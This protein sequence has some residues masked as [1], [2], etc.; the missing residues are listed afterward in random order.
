MSKKSIVLWSFIL[1][2][3]IIQYF[4]IHPVYDLQR[5]E[6][7]HLDLGK[8]LAWGYTS[9][10]PLTSWTSWLM[11]SSGHTLFWLKFFPALYGALT[12]WV[13]WKIIEELKGNWF[14]LILGAIATTFSILFRI[15]SLYQPNSLDYLCWTLLY[16]TLIKYTNTQHRNWLFAAAVAFAIGFLN[17]YNILFLVFGLFPALLL[18]EQRKWFLKKDFYL[19]LALALLLISPNL[20]WQFQHHLPVIKHMAELRATQLVN[21]NRMDLFKD[22]L[23]FFAG[24]DFVMIAGLIALIIYPPFRPH[25]FVLFSYIFTLLIFS[26]FQ[27][28]SYYA[29]GLI[30]VL[31]GFGTV[32]LEQLCS[33]GWT[34]RLR[35]VAI[36]LP[37][38]V[39]P[40][41]AKRTL[42]L[43]SPEEIIKKQATDKK[44]GVSRWEDGKDHPLPQDYAD[45]LGW[46]ELAEKVDRVYG[47]VADKKHIL[48]ICD[49]YGEAGAINFYSRYKNIDAV[50]FNADYKNWFDLDKNYDTVISIKENSLPNQGNPDEKVLFHKITVM[51]SIENPYAR[52]K[53][54]YILL[55]EEPKT[56]INLLLRKRI[57]SLN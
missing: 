12:T 49:N 36:V 11:L 53:G 38:V 46:R 10:P 18:G 6:F 13:V 41:F 29:I 52:E 42:P 22:Q 44:F 51:G 3:F 17:K 45:M 24:A 32:Y 33:K 55:L 26:Y 2:K 54:T 50:S 31:L 56:D 1:L 9:V 23:L 43:Y 20:I 21:M 19:F 28:K 14:A 48:V 34:R 5:D 8:H 39:F 30:P 25:R 40:S 15:N 57:A 4:V 35:P 16:Y 27:A 7:L 37:L 47:G